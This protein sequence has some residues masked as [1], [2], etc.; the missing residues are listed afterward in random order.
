LLNQD[1]LN[2]ETIYNESYSENCNYYLLSW[3]ASNDLTGLKDKINNKIEEL[4]HEKNLQGI[5]DYID[6]MKI[7]LINKEILLFHYCSAL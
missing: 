3:N 1:F 4:N 6:K 5:L 7:E 2:T